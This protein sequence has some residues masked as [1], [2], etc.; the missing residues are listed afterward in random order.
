MPQQKQIALCI[1]L[2]GFR[3]KQSSVIV[4][5]K[6]N[7]LRQTI[8]YNY[9]FM[10]AITEQPY[11]SLRVEI[12]HCKR[13]RGTQLLF[14]LQPQAFDNLADSNKLMLVPFGYGLFYLFQHF[15]ET[16]FIQHMIPNHNLSPGYIFGRE[17]QHRNRH[18]NIRLMPVYFAKP[19]LKNSQQHHIE[20]QLL[21]FTD[22]D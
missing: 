7:P 5:S 6:M 20:S 1:N 17:R 18:R 4:K 11:V 13:K 14:I 19:R 2:H 15:S 10:P 8:C 22:L 9:S 21:S 3:C 16:G 12:R